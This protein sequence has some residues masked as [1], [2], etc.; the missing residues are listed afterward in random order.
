[1]KDRAV[2]FDPNIPNIARVYDYWLGGKDNFQVDREFG[3]ELVKA[4][5]GMAPYMARQNRGFLERAVRFLVRECGIRQL[6]DIGT[7]L[8]TQRNV[9]EVAQEAAPGTHVVYVDNDPVVVTHGQAIL[10]ASADV[11]V[12]EA[13]LREPDVILT[14]P[15]LNKLIDFSQPVAVLMLAILHFIRD[16]YDPI[17]IIACF[18]E[19]M[20]PGSYLAI[21]HS[22]SEAAGPAA[23][24]RITAAYDQTNAPGQLRTREQIQRLFTGFELVEPGRLV[25]TQEWRAQQLRRHDPKS[26]W[27]LAGV[28]RKI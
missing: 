17:G 24:A 16:E 2:S 19:K 10:G 23:V 20:A 5:D 7:G 11:A 14:H 13:D 26:S 22:T 3:D 4:I 12:I 27:M 8:P 18:R 15:K 25:Y 28:G 9:H 6:I 21:S 1:V